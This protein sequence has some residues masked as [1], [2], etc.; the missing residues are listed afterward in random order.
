M[1]PKIKC[2]SVAQKIIVII[3]NNANLKCIYLNALHSLFFF[4][5]YITLLQNAPSAT[6]EKL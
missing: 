5:R 4:Y 3:N 2:S 1:L 6:P